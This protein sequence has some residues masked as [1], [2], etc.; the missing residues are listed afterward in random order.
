MNN[1]TANDLL[2]VIDAL[3]KNVIYRYLGGQSLLR[4][5]EVDQPDG[6]IRFNRWKRTSSETNAKAGLI[7]LQMLTKI[8]LAFSNKPNF[9]IHIDRVFS[10]GGNSRSALETLLAHTP[11]FYVCRPTRVDPFTGETINNLKH[12]IWRP[13]N[14]HEKGKVTQIDYEGVITELEIGSEMSDI[15]ITPE[16]KG[17][18]F[19]SLEAKR[20]HTQMQIALV[21]IGNALNFK[22]WIA[23]NDR[24]IPVGGTTLGQLPGVID[25]LN[26]IPLLYSQQLRDAAS[27]ID[28][29]WFTGDGNRIPALIEIE[30]STRVT[31]GLTRMLKFRDLVPALNLTFT[32]VAANSLR[33]RV[34]AE[35]NQA[36]FRNLNVRFM[37]YS[38]VRELYG[39]VNRYKLT[40]VVDHTFINPFMES[41]VTS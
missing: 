4:L 13:D 19:D 36:V 37:P 32:I 14:P 23:A 38:T 33:G 10:A 24:H 6:P 22:T 34:I 3:D 11:Y 31:S 21:M 39:L 8:A 27:L 7:S 2:S 41:V 28:C 26:S 1:L 5:I 9:P 40:N 12:L 35:A 17:T 18:E 29:I 20:T 16:M 15:H 30:H 25:S